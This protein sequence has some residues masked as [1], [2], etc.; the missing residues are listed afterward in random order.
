MK[1]VSFLVSCLFFVYFLFIYVYILSTLHFNKLYSS[2]DTNINDE[3][4][5]YLLTIYC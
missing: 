5:G 1:N 4:S 2:F 3:T